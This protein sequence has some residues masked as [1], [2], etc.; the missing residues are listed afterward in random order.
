MRLT[1]VSRWLLVTLLVLTSL[2]LVAG[3]PQ[4]QAPMR[5][6]VVF[7][8]SL[9]GSERA[10]LVRAAGGL[11]L[12]DLRLVNGGAA[13]LPP[14]AE[15][16]LLQRPQVLRIEEDLVMQA[17]GKPVKP[18]RV[19]KPTATPTQVPT[20]AHT[21]TPTLIQPTM[22]PTLQPTAG[23]LQPV[24]WGVTRV[25]AP[26]AWA[27]TRGAGV[28]VAI[29]DTGIA[30]DHPDLA[31]QVVGGINTIV[32]GASYADD[33]GHGTHVAGTI[34]AVDN[35][36]GVVG[37]AP[38]VSLLAVKVLNASGIG[39]LSDIIEGLQWCVANKG[40]YNIRV[41]NMSLGGGGAI[42]YQEAIRATTNAGI[43]IV[44]AAGNDGPPVAGGSTVKYPAAYP[45]AVAVSATD[46]QNVIA[47]FSSYGPE[48]DVAAPG[49]SIP[50][51]Y[52]NDAYT[53]MSGTS[54][55]TPHVAGV[56]ALV[57]ALHP[58]YSVAQV[59]AAIEGS[60]LDLGAAGLDPVYGWGLAQAAAISH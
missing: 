19:P 24:P 38:Q 12:K 28:S 57:A 59:R 40:A 55:A 23:P 18:T 29:L 14:Q 4:S 10:A 15:A 2:P 33:H 53:N 48:V 26:D 37:V 25:D 39:Y 52:L 43:L 35:S 17:L 31:G 51:T 60:A 36:I 58:A 11:V 27:S 42:S 3:L 20:V 56:A 7:D 44:A 41:V 54:M 13:A 8:G 6:I 30:L 45:E 5:R 21:P 22:V 1:V 46:S 16:A 34:A 49:V 50:S 9:P 47:Y 32:S